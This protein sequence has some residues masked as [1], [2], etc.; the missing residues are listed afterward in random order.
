MEARQAD[1]FIMW[2]W[3]AH[4]DCAAPRACA[5]RPMAESGPVADKF[6]L[7]AGLEGPSPVP[8]GREQSRRLLEVGDATAQLLSCCLVTDGEERG[9]KKNSGSLTCEAL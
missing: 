4:L 7:A 5:S 9:Q 1:V 3:E 8:L 2:P 6:R